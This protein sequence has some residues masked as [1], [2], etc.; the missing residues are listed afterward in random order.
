MVV[1][2]R[3]QVFHGTADKTPGGLEKSDLIQGNDGQIKSKA[4]VA[5]AKQRM[6][7]EGSKAMVKIFKPKKGEFKL[8]PKVGTAGY[9]KLIKKMKK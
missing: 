9:K 6:K 1:G 8:Q 4:A 7:D 3:A 2:T 5:A